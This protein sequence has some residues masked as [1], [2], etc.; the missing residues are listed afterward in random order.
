MKKGNINRPKLLILGGTGLVGSTLASYAQKIFDIHLTY[1]TNLPLSTLSSTK[2]S[3][4]DELSKLENLIVQYDPDVIVHTVS[5]PSV[6]WCQENRDLA[7]FL[8]VNLT[9]N[10][11]KFASKINSTLIYLSTDWVFDGTRNNKYTENDSTN[12]INHYGVTKLLAEKIV[13][14]YP[15]NVVLRPAVIYGWHKKSRF[16]NWIIDTLKEKKYVDPHVD[17]YATPTLVDDLALAIIKIIENKSSGLF[18][19]TGK[20]CVNRFEFATQIAEIFN[21]DTNLIK[22]VTQSEKPQKAP[23]P[24]RTCLDSSKLEN[25]INFNFHDITSGIEFIF[26]QSQKSNYE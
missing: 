24:N 20:S 6:D 15:Q 7:N 21:L 1:C 11:A 16:T 25:L 23:R 2:I 8:H 26:E 3:L 18:H 14:D 4:P 17:Q 12:P 10:I 5:H 9:E 13:L 19:S 22:P